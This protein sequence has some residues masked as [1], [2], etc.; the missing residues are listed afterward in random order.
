VK[1]N[2]QV[3]GTNEY[4]ALGKAIGDRLIKLGESIPYITGVPS[5]TVED[6]TKY[7][8]AYNH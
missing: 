6:M 1:V 7:I 5:A 2:P 8:S 4:G 3:K